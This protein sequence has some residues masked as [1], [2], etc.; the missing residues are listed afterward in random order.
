[1]DSCAFLWF[2]RRLVL[3]VGVAFLAATVPHFAY[4][5]TTTGNFST[6][7][8]ELSL[9]GFIVEIGLVAAA[10]MVAGR[11]LE[12]VADGTLATRPAARS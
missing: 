3:V 2:A 7:D 12:G 1:M 6:V 10:M 8:N 9:G 11:E 5:L 4:H